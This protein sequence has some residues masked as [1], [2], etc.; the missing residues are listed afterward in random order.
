MNTITVREAAL[1]G[2][3]IKMDDA[4]LRATHDHLVRFV[5]QLQ[6]GEPNYLANKLIKRGYLTRPH[7]AYVSPTDAGRSAFAEARQALGVP[8]V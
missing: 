5:G 7:R 4:G 1:L 2:Y 6:L 8:N 3:V